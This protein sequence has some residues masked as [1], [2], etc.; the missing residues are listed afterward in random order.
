M[1]VYLYKKLPPVKY[2]LVILPLFIVLTLS[3]QTNNR[4]EIVLS[5]K[6]K[7]PLDITSNMEIFTDSTGQL[8][9]ENIPSRAFI[10]NTKDYF[11]FPFS[12][13]VY[14]IRFNLENTDAISKDWVLVWNNAMVEKL[15][16]YLSDSANA[17]FSHTE[18]RLYTTK[19]LK[20]LYEESPHYEFTLSPK[21]S[22][23]LYIK[24]SNKRGS[25]SRIELF[26]APAFVNERYDNFASQGII[27]GLVFFRFFLVLI[28]GFFIIKDPIFKAYSFQIITKTAA[29]FSLQ[30]IL[31]P[32]FT[33]NPSWAVIINF[34]GINTTVIGSC[35]V[36]FYA[37]DVK[38]FPKWMS[39]VLCFFI[40][41]TLLINIVNIFDYQWYWLK[42][43]VWGGTVSA[44]FIFILYAYAIFKKSPINAPYSIPFILGIL[45]YF[46]VNLR[47]LTGV[48]IKLAFTISL[49]L[50]LAEILV[51]VLFLG[52]IYRKSE[53]NKVIAEQDSNFNLEQNKRLQEI[54][55]LKTTFFTN[56]SHEL[57]TPLTLVAS[58]IQ[59]LIA[60][61]PTEALLPIMHR[62]AQRLL[63][64]INQLLDI[65]K[66]EAGQMKVEVSEGNISKYLKTLTSSFISLAESKQID[67][68][69]IQ[70]QNDVVA[71]FDKDKLDKI[72]TNLLSN[73]FK[74]TPEGG[75]V[76]VKVEY[77]P[78]PAL[79]RWEGVTLAP[80]QR[81]RVGVGWGG[82]QIE[83]S[84]TG[85]GIEEAHLAQIFDR[86]Y[87]IDG[88]QNRNYEGTGIGL[89][90]V[91]ELM[92]V[93]KGNITVNS[94][95]NVGTTF[96]L[97]LPIDYDTWK[98][99]TA[100]PAPRRGA[101][102]S[103]PT[104]EFTKGELAKTPPLWAG[105]L[106]P[107]N[108]NILLVVD[109]NADIR[110]YV[111]SIFE[112]SYQIIEA[113]N[114]K[115]GIQKAQETVPNLI[116]SDLMMPEMDGFAFCKYL[117]TN[118]T[119]SHIPIVMLTAKANV[120]SRI[121]GLELGADDYLIKPFNTQEIRVRV[122]NLLE[123]QE[124]LRHYF[125]KNNL[126]I[127]TESAEINPLEVA[128]FKKAKAVLE[129]HLSDSTY[130][131]EQF[132]QDM[133]MSGSQLRRKLK[134]LTDQTTVEFIRNFR[135]ER[136]SQLLVNKNV[137]EVAFGVGFESLSYFTKSF[138]EKF[139]V[140]PSEYQH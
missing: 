118:E 12:N 102:N 59:D 56:I 127:T 85:L 14:W 81:G 129:D 126:E 44:V 8:P 62:N 71:Y 130:D 106:L 119:T 76:I 133:N 5:A 68:Q 98:E 121:E 60:K 33:N 24:L 139:G 35:V 74:F 25:F 97:N 111:R 58:P 49:I 13:N 89:A 18:Q 77:S 131:V 69:F 20:K 93:L 84:D 38:R 16:F 112:D 137:S 96:K 22:K 124:N 41:F 63:T 10:K 67:F 31:G 120:E 9:F 134:A 92:D 116:I 30:N 50:F 45:S 55:T 27:N 65:S 110:A 3:A 94:E 26:S 21:S 7:I 122:K 91:K 123:K 72:I 108:A 128:F 61:Y 34:L 47:L 54:D 37:L 99:N 100:P 103:S 125:T 86:F 52:R 138:Q 107:D 136:A 66:L 11:F 1:F 73:A 117:K 64:L 4:Q 70:N 83:V 105:G 75:K 42:A 23:T 114:G 82:V 48:E 29:F 87:Q 40:G 135:L 95:K 78:T 43:G 57:R 104:G 15:D 140:S 88:K 32:I 132:G 51:F 53:R 79:P 115:D 46:L 101:T 2:F 19:K 109:D 39:Y 36:V 90:L 80:S 28:L 6:S 17:N 113:I